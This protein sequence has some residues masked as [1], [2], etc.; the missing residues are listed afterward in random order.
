[1]GG[2]GI[3]N[4]GGG[5]VLQYAAVC[6]VASSRRPEGLHRSCYGNKDCATITIFVNRL[7]RPDIDVVHIATPDHWHAVQGDMGVSRR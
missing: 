7:A 5:D 1:M 4:Q 2:I 3:G 6:D